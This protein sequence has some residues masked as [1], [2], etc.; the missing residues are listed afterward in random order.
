MNTGSIIEVCCQ[1]I[2]NVGNKNSAMH[3]R[4]E[5]QKVLDASQS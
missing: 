2:A 3:E 1:D 4:K 5:K